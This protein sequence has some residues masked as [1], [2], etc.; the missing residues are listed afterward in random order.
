MDTPHS[1]SRL[2]PPSSFHKGWFFCFASASHNAFSTAAFAIR[3]PRTLA[4]KETLSPPELSV[5]PSTAGARYFL[6][7]GQALS[8]HSEL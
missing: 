2:V 4:S 3:C 6:I 1:I 7:V 5:F 8:I